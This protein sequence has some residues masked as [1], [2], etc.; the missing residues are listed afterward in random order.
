MLA[1]EKNLENVY[2]HQFSEEVNLIRLQEVEIDQTLAQEITKP[3]P[4]VNENIL[5]KLTRIK[6]LIRIIK[7]RQALPPIIV[8]KQALYTIPRN[9]KKGLQDFKYEIKD[10]R[11]RVAASILLNMIFIP[12]IITEK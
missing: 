11:R 4:Y 1:Q 2:N 7:E 10:G 5:G 12:A 8:N 6:K 9:R 3:H